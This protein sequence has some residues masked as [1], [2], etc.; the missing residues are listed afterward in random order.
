MSIEY[1]EQL[2]NLN[3]EISN[4]YEIGYSQKNNKTNYQAFEHYRKIFHFTIVTINNIKELF[5]SKIKNDYTHYNRILLPIDRSIKDEA[6]FISAYLKLVTKTTCFLVDN[7]HITDEHIWHETLFIYRPELNQLE[8]YDPNGI[9]IFGDRGI[10]E[11]F[12]GIILKDN[13][14]MTFIPSVVLQSFENEDIFKS[15]SLNLLSSLTKGKDSVDGWCQIWSLIIYD[16]VI[17]YDKLSTKKIIKSIY[18][19]LRSSNNGKKV[20]VKEA[21]FKAFYIIRGYFFLYIDLTNDCLQ[22]QFLEIDAEILES[23]D[24]YYVKSD[25]RLYEFIDKSLNKRLLKTPKMI[26]DE[27]WLNMIE[28]NERLRTIAEFRSEKY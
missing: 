10:F 3:W 5:S 22:E 17:R 12:I 27:E 24:L 8:H 25:V 13:P 9:S 7:R 28:E 16:L 21:A 20:K 18:D 1:N 6:E 15:K 2:L 23:F 14:N 19:F 4:I 11:T 26:A